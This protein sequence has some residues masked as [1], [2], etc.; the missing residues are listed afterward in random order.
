MRLV[1]RIFQ[2]L[3]AGLFIFAAILQYNDVDIVRW[4]AIYL[5][6]ATVCIFALLNRPMPGLAAIVALIA[7]A[8]AAFYVVHGAWKVSLPT[9]FLEWEM[10]DQTIVAGR[11]MNGLFIICFWMVVTWV[12]GRKPAAKSNGS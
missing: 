1:L 4:A 6:A 5:A 12:T 2:G 7:I 3:M 8:W 11:E 10:K 9:L